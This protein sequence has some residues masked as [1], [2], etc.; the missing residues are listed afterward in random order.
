MCR[1]ENHL[2]ITTG[3]VETYLPDRGDNWYQN[4]QFRRRFYRKLTMLK[5]QQYYYRVFW[6]WLL[7]LRN[8]LRKIVSEV[9]CVMFVFLL[10]HFV[11]NCLVF[12]LTKRF[13]S[14]PFGIVQ[15]YL[16]V[17]ERYFVWNSWDYMW[18]K[19]LYDGILFNHIYLTLVILYIKND[20]FSLQ[21]ISICLAQ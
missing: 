21:Q 4:T 2:M 9:L 20:Q 17:L 3:E 12:L 11:V 18:K 16:S 19:W 5:K 8:D 7:T 15:F 14:V 1:Y 6:Q 13:L 10:F